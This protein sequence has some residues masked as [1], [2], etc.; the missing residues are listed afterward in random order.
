MRVFDLEINGE[1]YKA[2]CGLRVLGKLQKKYGSLKEFEKKIAPFAKAGMEDGN[3]NTSQDME[4]DNVDI[5]AVINT[6][7]LFLDEGAAAFGTESGAGQVA[8]ISGSPL[9]L[10]AQLFNIYVESMM[11]ENEEPEKN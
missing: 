5:E 2:C 6:A 7:E 9:L 8:F 3:D 1:R 11:P 4:E 10:A